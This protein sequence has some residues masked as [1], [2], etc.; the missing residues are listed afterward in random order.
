MTLKEEL[1]PTGHPT[2]GNRRI[3][4]PPRKRQRRCQEFGKATGPIVRIRR[5]LRRSIRLIPAIHRYLPLSI[6]RRL[7]SKVKAGR[8]YRRSLTKK[9]RPTYNQLPMYTKRTT[10]HLEEITHESAVN[11]D[12]PEPRKLTGPEHNRVGD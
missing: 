5:R 6:S 1:V 12:R 4:F 8:Q 11:L 9:T 3:R 10:I 7:P 2:H